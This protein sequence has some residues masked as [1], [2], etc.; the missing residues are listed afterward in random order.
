MGGLQ[1][2]QMA[3]KRTTSVAIQNPG[4]ES[5]RMARLRAT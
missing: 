3:G 2:H 4:T 1:P 5:P